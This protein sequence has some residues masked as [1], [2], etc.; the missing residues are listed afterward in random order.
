[1]A[2]VLRADTD[3]Q[4]TILNAQA[5]QEAEEFQSFM[6][7]ESAKRTIAWEQEKIELRRM[8]DFDMGE[9]RREIENQLAIDSDSRQKSKLDAKIQ[10]LRDARERRDITEPE[11]E[12][13][14]FELEMGVVP[15]ELSILDQGDD[16]SILADIWRER[17]AGD[18]TPEQTNSA[19][20]LEL[21]NSTAT[22]NEVRQDIKAIL[23]TGDPVKIKHAL[24]ILTARQTTTGRAEALGKATAGVPRRP[25]DDPVFGR[26][27]VGL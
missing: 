13:A 25:G 27:A 4:K 6:Q 3:I 24:D 16:A 5:R 22:S 18:A 2:N 20:L 11:M 21:A 8:H 7:G 26:F 19:A 12:R 1:M 14:F 17:D 23:S 9:Q 10:S 15:S